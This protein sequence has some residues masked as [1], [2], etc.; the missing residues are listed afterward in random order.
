MVRLYSFAISLSVF[1]FGS[2]V[3]WTQA[4]A[5]PLSYVS[6][7]C[8]KR[9]MVPGG[10][11]SCPTS[12]L[13]SRQAQRGSALHP[14]YSDGPFPDVGPGVCGHGCKMY[15]PYRIWP[16]RSHMYN[17]PTAYHYIPWWTVPLFPPPHSYV[18]VASVRLGTGLWGSS[19]GETRSQGGSERRGLV[20]LREV[21]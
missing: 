14:Y 9:L 5:L 20:S 16:H 2:A 1:I 19:Q 6:S 7:P 13:C 15:S 18:S 21:T 10:L 11:P 8:N 17:A 4:S 12:P 3:D